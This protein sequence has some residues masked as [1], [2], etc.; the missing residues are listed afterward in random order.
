[1]SSKLGVVDVLPELDPGMIDVLVLLAAP[2]LI[3]KLDSPALVGVVEACT[4]T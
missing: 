3:H 2:S 4:T 1:M